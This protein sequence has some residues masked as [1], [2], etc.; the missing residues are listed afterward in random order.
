MHIN[1]TLW[2]CIRWTPKFKY[3]NLERTLMHL[4]A[5]KILL[6]KF[7]AVI[8]NISIRK[9]GSSFINAKENNLHSI[10]IIFIMQA[11]KELTQSH[12]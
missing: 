3:F 2:L 6:L 1:N 4:V 9:L 12:G 7:K 5:H 11:Y 8:W 10:R